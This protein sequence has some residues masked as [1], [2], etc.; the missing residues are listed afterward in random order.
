MTL[1]LS[2]LLQLTLIEALQCLD[3]ILEQLV[4]VLTNAVVHVFSD[5][6]IRGTVDLLSIVL[7]LYI[8]ELSFRV[9]LEI[10]G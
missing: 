6:H 1:L 7:T 4:E 3:D 8:L 10:R 5:V 9:E 2:K